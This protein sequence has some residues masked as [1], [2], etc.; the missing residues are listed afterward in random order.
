[1][2]GRQLPFI[3]LILPFY[4]IAL[5]GGMRSLK[6]L[7]P[8]LL[9]A[10]GSFALCQFVT[11]NYIDY[12]LTECCLAGIADRHAAVPAGVEACARSGIRGERGGADNMVTALRTGAL[13][14]LGA[15]ADRHRVVIIWTSLQDL[16]HRPQSIHG[17]ASTRR[18]RSPSTTTSL[19]G[20]LGIPAARRPARRSC[21]P[22]SSRR[23]SSASRPRLLPLRRAHVA[24][25][26]L[27]ILTVC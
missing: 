24:A 5:Y 4:V 15:V 21:S 7:W 8:V 14:G 10:G 12:T 2:I 13:A 26:W 25:V 17:R 20:G 11:S 23:F 6:A 16:R 3:A 27:A 9:V 22:R 1:M 19:R 18:S